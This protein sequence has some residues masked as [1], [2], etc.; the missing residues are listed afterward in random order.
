M[1]RGHIHEATPLVTLPLLGGSPLT[2]SFPDKYK[3]TQIQ[4]QMQIQ[5]Q[6]QIQIPNKQVAL[7]V[8]LP[9]CLLGS[10]CS[11]ALI[12]NMGLPMAGHRV[13]KFWMVYLQS[14]GCSHGIKGG[15]ISSV[16][17]LSDYQPV[18]SLNFNLY[19]PHFDFS[20]S[21]SHST[22]V[23]VSFEISDF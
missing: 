4:I 12:F 21:L 20:S 16:K 17:C 3:N 13:F 6:K 11:R 8:A 22:S 18:F 19:I 2:V 14:R 9:D 5:I 15:F 7:L 1:G 23:G 10:R